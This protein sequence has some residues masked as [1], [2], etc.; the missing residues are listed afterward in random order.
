MSLI[1]YENVNFLVILI[2]LM[3][4]I[5]NISVGSNPESGKASC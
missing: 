1:W 5:G 4:I 2:F 3:Q